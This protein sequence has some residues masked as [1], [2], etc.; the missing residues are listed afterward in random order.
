[1]RVIFVLLAAVLL[2]AAVSSAQAENWCGFIDK[3]HSR[4][5]CGFS[6]LDECKQTI[7]DNKAAYC[8]PDPNFAARDQA[9]VRLAASRF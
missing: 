5:R 9:D 3:D 4:V 8:M 7:G 2:T 6:S 1:M